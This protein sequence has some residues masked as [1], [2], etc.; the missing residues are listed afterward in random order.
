MNLE[1]IE[2]TLKDKPVFANLFQFYMY[3]FSEMVGFT[4]TADG[5]FDESDLDDC[6]VEPWCHSFLLKVDGELAG[7]AIVDEIPAKYKA[8]DEDIDLADFFVLRKFRGKG[9]GEQFAVNLFDRFKGKWRVG[10]IQENTGAL[11]FWRKVI[12]K[13]TGGNFVDTTW[14]SASRRGTQQ[15]FTRE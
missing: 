15:F 2:T 7:L 11:A 12:G 3:D 10:Q 4:V 1:I 8:Q 6:W 5:R 14:Q 9:I 13:Y